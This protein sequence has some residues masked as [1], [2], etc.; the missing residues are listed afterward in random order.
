MITM[1]SCAVFACIVTLSWQENS[2]YVLLALGTDIKRCTNNS[3]ATYQRGLAKLY[4]ELKAASYRFSP[5]FGG[6]VT[7]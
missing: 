5:P 1:P 6:S 2:T 7:I 3:Q 4:S